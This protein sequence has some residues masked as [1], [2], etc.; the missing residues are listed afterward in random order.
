MIRLHERFGLGVIA[1]MLIGAVAA[2]VIGFATPFEETRWAN[3][4]FV[5]LLPHQLGFF[6]ADGRITRLSRGAL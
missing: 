6:Y 4:A 1:V 3:V 2:D 5:W